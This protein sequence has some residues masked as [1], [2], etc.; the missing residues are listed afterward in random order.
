MLKKENP[1]SE[2]KTSFK[3]ETSEGK[4]VSD[5]FFIQTEFGKSP[6]V[7]FDLLFRKYYSN[8]CN[9]AVRFVYSQEIAEDIVA[10]VFSN[11]WQKEVYKTINTSYRSYLYTA[12][13][14]RSFNYLKYEMGRTSKEDFNE[15]LTYSNQNSVQKPDEILQFQ[16]LSIKIDSVIQHLPKQSKKA[17]LLHRLEG[18]KYSEIAKELGI[19]ISAVERLISRALSK[20]REQLK[21]EDSI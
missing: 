17:F 9:H 16:E 5:E 6:K 18:Q 8:L 1:N 4:V 3:T 11:F 12:V 15:G 13:R 20:L 21:S 14:F 19:T 2:I 7:G 10:E